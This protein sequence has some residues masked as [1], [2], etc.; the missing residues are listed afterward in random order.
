MFGYVRPADR[1]LKVREAELYRAL[2]CGLCRTMKRRTGV[3]ST[4]T[5]QYDMVFLV[6]VRQALTGEKPSLRRRRCGPH[7]LRA[8][9]MA[10]ATE[11]SRYAASVS[12]VLTEMHLEDD[13]ADESFGK[14]TAAR[15]ALPL[16]RGMSRRG[17]TEAS[18]RAAMEHQLS[19]LAALEAENT[20]SIDGP[21]DCFGRMLAEV[22][23]HGLGEKEA[24]IAREIGYRTGRFIYT[25]DA[26]ADAAEDLRKG[27]FN[28]AL[29]RYGAEALREGAWAEEPAEEL[30]CAV[31]L[32]LER[33][34]AA[35]ELLPKDGDG[36]VSIIRNIVY[37]GMPAAFERAL[38]CR[39][40]R[41]GKEAADLG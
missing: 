28:P 30:R 12:A 5:L 32:D 33:L 25:A 10:E 27:R 22:F 19:A 15:C 11:A 16:A 23:G 1:E 9:P 17:R 24:R 7:P 41:S 21:A 8:R 20:D 35:A 36:I 18:L 38:R 29:N 39:P 40:G 34:A 14:R 31:R 26:A 6:L 13:V 37:L 2:Y 4:L 3:L